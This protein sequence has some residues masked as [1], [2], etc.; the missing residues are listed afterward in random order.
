MS[1]GSGIVTSPLRVVAT[2]AW[3]AL[4]WAGLRA[5]RRE[6]R[7]LADAL[8]VLAVSGTLGVAAYLNLKAGSSLGWGILPEGTPHEARE[9]D[10]FFILG[11]WSWGCFAGVGAVA[12][13]RRWR[14]P[15]AVGLAAVLLPLVGNWRSVDRSREPD[16]SAASQFG[17]ALL[18][19]A[20]EHAVLF[21]GGD[22]DSYPIWY[23]QQV[24]GVRR[25][26]L[27]VTVPL[28]PTEWYPAEL[29]RRSGLRW[30]DG[31][32]VAGAR[33]LSEQRAA[34]IAAAASRVKRPVA[35]SPALEAAERSLLGSG[36]VLRGPVFV[37]QAA[38][39]EA[40]AGTL[41][42]VDSAAAAGWVQRRGAG[43][44]VPPSLSGDDVVRVM[45]ALLDCPRLLAATT[46]S[47]AQRDSLEVHCNLR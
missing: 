8:V 12:L 27:T 25:D 46:S 13:A 20:P 18:E 19:S 7:E 41:A 22:N 38:R 44:V 1:W 31:E 34:L 9:R 30:N 33:T 10:Y 21:L 37:A 32:R 15:A 36:W 39:R 29:P 23:L 4:A 14:L 2:I 42:A 40:G 5:L 16:A 11:F 43:S 6:S 26:V 35:A 28:L 17:R 3:I 24:E 45:L 47:R